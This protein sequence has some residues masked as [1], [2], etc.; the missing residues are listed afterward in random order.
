MLKLIRT[1]I[2]SIY[3]VDNYCETENKESDNKRLD[4]KIMSMAG[5][6]NNKKDKV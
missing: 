5:A 4:F 2:N 1:V 6:I 3:S